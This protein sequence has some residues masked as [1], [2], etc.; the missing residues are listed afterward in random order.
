[1]KQSEHT[2]EIYV[3][4]RCNMCNISIYFCNTDIKQ[5]QHTYKTSETLETHVGNTRFQRN[6]SFLF[7]NGGS[8]ARGV[9][10]CRARRWREARRSGEEGRGKS[11]G[12]A[13]AG[14]RTLEGYVRREARGTVE[15]EEDGLLHYGAVK[16]SAV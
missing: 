9:H 6:I 14:P 11:S 5:L 3:Y 12:E 13:A 2:L 7:E 8:S 10:R 1:M 16:M 4:S 15:R